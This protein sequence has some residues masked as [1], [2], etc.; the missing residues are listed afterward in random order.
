[1]LAESSKLENIV[2]ELQALETR[3][4]LPGFQLAVVGEFNRGKSTLINRLLG[5]SLVPV[6]TL[7]TT[8]IPTFI[9]PGADECME[10]RFSKKHSEVRSLQEAS[11]SDLLGT[12]SGESEMVTQVQLTVDDPWLRS[13]DVELIDAPGIGDLNGHHTSLVFDLLSQCDA[14]ILVV[15]A[16]SPFGMGEGAFLKQ[17]MMGR[18]IERILV[19]VSHLDTIAQEDRARVLTHIRRRVTEVSEKITI[20]PLHPVDHTTEAVVLNAVRTQIATMVSKGERKAW[21]SQQVAGQLADHLSQMSQIGEAAIATA[22]MNPVEREKAL[23][24]AQAEVQKAELRWQKIRRELDKR[25]QQCYQLL[26][27]KIL[28]AKTELLE[29]LAFELSRTSNPK[30]WWER[31][32][33][34]RLRR[35]FPSLSRKSE[36]LFLK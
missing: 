29:V 36:D 25:C 5:R 32:L 27:E 9:T 21:R 24:Q 2:S 4:H 1:M 31:E 14:A 28:S 33:P 26:K 15:S 35:E 20:L 18:H 3:W 10:V 16:N 17:E 23:Q 11:W 13:L 22:R 6:G 7:S 30:L 8:A 34:F 12:A 19:V